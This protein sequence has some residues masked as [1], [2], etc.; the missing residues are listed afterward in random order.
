MRKTITINGKVYST[1]EITFNSICEFEEMGVSMSDIEEKSMMFVRG[2]AAMC[3]GKKAEQ[4]GQEIEAH[5]LGGGDMG[6]ITEAL[7]EAVEE[8]GFF[9]ALSKRAKEKDAES[10]TA[11]AE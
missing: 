8:S 3:M 5:I 11:A 4:A 1:K 10:Q 6:E 9:Q 2:Y 7:K